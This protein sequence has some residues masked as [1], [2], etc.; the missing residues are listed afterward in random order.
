MAPQPSAIADAD[1]ERV[2]AAILTRSRS[3]NVAAMLALG[4]VIDELLAAPGATPAAVVDVLVEAKASTRHFGRFHSAVRS[5]TT[6][7]LNNTGDAIQSEAY[8]EAGIGK[9]WTWLGVLAEKSRC[10]T[11]LS[12]PDGR[13]GGCRQRHGEVFTD[14]ELAIIGNPRGGGTI[15]G[16]D[17]RCIRAPAEATHTERDLEVLEKGSISW[18]GK[19]LRPD[20]IDPITRKKR[21]RRSA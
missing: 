10:P 5:S 18:R 13:G 12:L 6:A 14:E 15:C 2:L 9:A 17:C 1:L 16:D 21:V 11:G 4:S 7:A 8:R 3:A 20:L 19:G